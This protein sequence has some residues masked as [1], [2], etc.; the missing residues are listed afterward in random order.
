M[1]SLTIAGPVSIILRAPDSRLIPNDLQRTTS[2]LI[3]HL[4]QNRKSLL[5]GVTLTYIFSIS[6]DVILAAMPNG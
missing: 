3:H 4:S 2:P 5:A 1:H 6:L